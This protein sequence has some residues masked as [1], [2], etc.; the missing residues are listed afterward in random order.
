MKTV[1]SIIVIALLLVSKLSFC[2]IIPENTTY[3]DVCVE[4]TNIS[5]YPGVSLIGM[6]SSIITS[7]PQTKSSFTINSNTCIQVGS[8]KYSTFSM[9]AVRSSYIAG[10]DI[11][12]VD[13]SK[14][15]NAISPNVTI[16][17]YGYYVN[18]TSIVSSIKH[19]YKI[20]GFTPT[21]IVLYEWKTV[22][23]YNNGQADDVSLK[24]YSGDVSTLSQTITTPT[25]TSSNI[26]TNNSVFVIYPNPT[27]KEL[28]LK[29]SNNYF[30]NV[31]VKII[32]AEGKVV[33]SSS[34]L[35]DT[36]YLDFLL[37]V[38]MLKK[39]SYV[40]SIIMGETIDSRLL[41]VE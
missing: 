37:Y 20:V 28:H 34:V 30:G 14:D 24:S 12:T 25:V 33:R 19:Y 41:M 32:N 29:I 10:K 5:E 1:K 4:I 38:D 27:A 11:S 2:D 16:D 36:G 3:V 9:Y 21:N 26:Q 15:K 7:T 22:T 39:D 31:L 40:V 8:S 18:K 23:G 35:K 17:P 13:W 6:Q